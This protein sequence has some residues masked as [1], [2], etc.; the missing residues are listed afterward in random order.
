MQNAH[1]LDT[2][3]EELPLQPVAPGALMG[4]LKAV[5]ADLRG[6]WLLLVNT[7]K[8]IAQGKV[9]RTSLFEQA[10]NIGNGSVLFITV[11]MVVLGMIIVV[12][13]GMQT[14]RVL[15]ELSLLGANII[16]LLVREF[17][18][19]VCAMMLATRVAAGIAAE[20]G[21]MVVTDQVDALR[22]SGAQPIE[23]LVVPRFIAGLV[24]SVALSFWSLFI[25]LIAGTFAA[26]AVFDLNI[27]TFV[28]FNLVG[29]GDYIVFMLKASTF[30]A[31]IPII[32]AQRGLTT[33][34]GSEGVG[35]ATTNAVV[36]SSLA[37]I[38]LDL[39]LSVLGYIVFPPS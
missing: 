2:S 4:A 36:H 5:G 9:D 33:F 12:Q 30:G 38:I 21:S 19:I 16:Q 17:A 7:C 3:S 14:Q 15:P 25:S 18:P 22:M 32:S 31:A 1:S 34:G 20:I 23:Y 27:T 29:M 11:T 39:I 28:N 26:N 35:W 8:A 10:Y 24:M 37:I 13:S 6:L